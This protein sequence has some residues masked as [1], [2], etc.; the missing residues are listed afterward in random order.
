ML[1][2]LIILIPFL[3][4]VGVIYNSIKEQKRLENSKLFK[5]IIEERKKRSKAGKNKKNDDDEW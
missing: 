1:L 4:L 2:T 5:D 3:F